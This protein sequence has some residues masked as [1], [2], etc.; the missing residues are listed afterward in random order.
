MQIRDSNFAL[1]VLLD[2]HAF[3]LVKDSVRKARYRQTTIIF[4]RSAM[5]AS[6][7]LSAY[8]SFNFI[9]GC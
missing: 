4:R 2:P 5:V 6:V 3:G 7:F 9:F 8:I 1:H